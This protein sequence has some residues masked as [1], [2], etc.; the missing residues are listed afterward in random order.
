MIR[1]I[2]QSPIQQK[3]KSRFK[4]NTETGNQISGIDSL[5]V[6]HD[7]RHRKKTYYYSAELFFVKFRVPDLIPQQ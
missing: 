1:L 6:T 5:C 2:S 4:D 7:N 3:S